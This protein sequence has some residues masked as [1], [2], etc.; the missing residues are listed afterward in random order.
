[1]AAELF[2]SL[3]EKRFAK[4]ILTS[5]VLIQVFLF[6]TTIQGDLRS[7]RSP[8]RWAHPQVSGSVIGIL[9]SH[10]YYA[11]LRSPL[12]DGDWDFT[13]EYQFYQASHPA[14]SLLATRT[15]TGRPPNH[16]S[17][18]PAL[19]WSAAVIPVHAVLPQ[20][21]EEPH[22]FSAP[23]NLAIGTVTF[24]LSLATLLFL[25]KIARMFA[26]PVPAAV[27]AAI[28]LLGTPII[29]YG[30]VSVGMAHG[31]ASAALAG[32]VCVWVRTFGSVRP[33]R[34]VGV[35]LLLGVACLMRW[36]LA[37]F[38]ILPALEM[39]W[40][41]RGNPKRTGQF[42]ALAILAAIGSV[43]GFIPQMVAWS[44]VYGQPLLNPHHTKPDWTAPEFW[45]VLAS[46]DRSLFYWT[47]A[48][49]FGAIGLFAAS[50]PQR[51]G[52]AQSRF[53]LTAVAIQI[54]MIAA[55]ITD[56]SIHL[57]YSFGFRFLTETCV[58]LVVGVAVLL[59]WAARRW[60]VLLASVCGV[61][62][63]WNLLLVEVYNR[64]VLGVEDGPAALVNGVGRSIIRRP[65]DAS[66]FTVLALILAFRF[67][68]GFQAC[69]PASEAP[70][71]SAGR[72]GLA[73]V[74]GQLISRFRRMFTH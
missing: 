59:R 23:Y 56:P 19:V 43:I 70:V 73:K 7:L 66:L 1:M 31:P 42:L 33:R 8:G 6:G 17:I 68:R 11:W 69:I 55:A 50:R 20:V 52:S 54:Y 14:E 12:I 16:W 40:L 3:V 65:F 67:W 22:G 32:Y 63:S 29:A 45:R 39:V 58:V 21:G 10:G 57:G 37:T 27:A 24:A 28:V 46:P 25:Y 13:N 53:L 36:Q 30:T 72:G 5:V 60:P 41:A 9:D 48:A 2:S 51:P 49:L 4:R 34:W 64:C 47:P 71:V 74:M 61:A 15:R 18:G 38:A 26:S 35:G 62:V 44:V